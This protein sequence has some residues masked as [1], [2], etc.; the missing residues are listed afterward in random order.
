MPDKYQERCLET[1]HT[2]RFEPVN[3]RLHATLGLSGEAGELTELLKKDTF[4][5]GH[6]TTRT[7]RLEELGDVFYY[8]CILAHLDGCTIEELSEQNYFKLRG[9]HGWKPDH[10]N[11]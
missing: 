10:V 6:N 11:D 5:P 7:Q 4:K 8:L 1:W 9:G 3:Q 2:D